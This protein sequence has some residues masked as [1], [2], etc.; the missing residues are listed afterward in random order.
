MKKSVDE[1]KER[2]RDAFYMR[3]GYSPKKEDITVIESNEDA[4]F[5]KLFANGWF[6][7]VRSDEQFPDDFFYLFR[8][9]NGK[10]VRTTF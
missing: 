4:S 9:V 8:L 7:V 1:L 5:I 2:C 6:Y 3:I 10:E